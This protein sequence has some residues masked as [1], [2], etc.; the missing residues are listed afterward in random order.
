MGKD[1][2]SWEPSPDVDVDTDGQ[3]SVVCDG[4]GPVSRGMDKPRGFQPRNPAQQF[5]P[6]IHVDTQKC[7]A[8]VENAA[9]RGKLISRA[10]RAAKYPRWKVTTLLHR[11]IP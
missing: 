11:E 1:L 3:G 8:S 9:F 5:H 2:E 6:T 10:Q 7:G 4:A